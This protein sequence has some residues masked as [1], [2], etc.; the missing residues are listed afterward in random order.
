MG[1]RSSWAL[2]DGPDAIRKRLAD[3]SERAR[4][5]DEMQTKLASIGQKDYSYAAIAGFP[6]DRS[7][8]GKTIPEVAAMNGKPNTLREEIDTILEMIDKGGAQ[9]VYHSMG[10]ED[11]ERIM[12]YPNT[13]F[14][15]EAGSA[16]SGSGS[17]IHVPTARMLAFWR[18]MC[19]RKTC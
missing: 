18:G 4:I 6:A 16:S 7:Y 12:R 9:M 1:S 10:D 8:D 19:V 13:A 5:V 3:T 17:R 14:G 2:A 15:S 11:V